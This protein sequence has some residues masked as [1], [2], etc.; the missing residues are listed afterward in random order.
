MPTQMQA[1]MPDGRPAPWVMTE[2]DLVEFLRIQNVKF[3]H[4]TI[5]RIRQ[6]YGLRGT[7]LGKAVRYQLPDVL[8][9]L[10]RIATE[11]PR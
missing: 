11:N 4:N 5:E 3:T 2:D 7:Q 1:F 6:K 9:T 8:R 10:E